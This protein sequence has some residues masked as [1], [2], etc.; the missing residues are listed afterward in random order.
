MLTLVPIIAVAPVTPQVKS[1]W[2]ERL[3]EALQDDD[4]PYIE[5]LGQHWG[6]L[7]STPEL[8]SQWADELLPTQRHV[9]QERRAGGFAIFAGACA[10]AAWRCRP[11]SARDRRHRC[12]HGSASCWSAKVHR[13]C[14]CERF[15]AV[16]PSELDSWY[17]DQEQ[18][19]PHPHRIRQHHAEGPR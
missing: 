5:V 14:G 17:Q 4:P 8:A 7:C 10:C 6:E 11:R 16:D 3:Y 9:L 13:G 12:R 18:V 15:A 1:K 19:A 2:L